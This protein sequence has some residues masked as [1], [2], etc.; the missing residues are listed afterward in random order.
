MVLNT[1][2][3]ALDHG[4][5]SSKGDWTVGSVRYLSELL[6]ATRGQGRPVVLVADQ[7]HVLDRTTEGPLPA[8][9][10]ESARWR[11]G[12][13]QDQPSDDEVHLAGPRVLEGGGSITALWRE[14]QRYT[15]PA[16]PATTAARPWR[17]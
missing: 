10:V 13:P 3:D 7:G 12:P 4:Q 5:E 16:R 17:K 8:Q 15:P 14:D 6:D 11:I 9:G 2:D 1:I